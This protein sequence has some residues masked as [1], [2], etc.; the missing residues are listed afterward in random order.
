MLCPGC[1]LEIMVPPGALTREVTASESIHS[2]DMTWEFCDKTQPGNWSLNRN[3]WIIKLFF[4]EG[5]DI[6]LIKVTRYHIS[7]NAC[8]TVILTRAHFEAMRNRQFE[9][10]FCLWGF[11][12]WFLLLLFL[13]DQRQFSY[14]ISL[15]LQRC[16]PPQTFSPG[17]TFSSKRCI[18]LSPQKRLLSSASCPCSG[19][20]NSLNCSRNRL[21]MRAS[22]QSSSITGTL[23]SSEDTDMSSGLGNCP[24]Q[25]LSLL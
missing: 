23:G 11:L 25:F 16:L 19:S 6:T 22:T 14:S 10:T 18:F 17:P 15:K 13:M 9:C 21:R 20:Q 7:Y 12:L 4:L 1:H 5:L 8:H 2:M 24:L 3:I